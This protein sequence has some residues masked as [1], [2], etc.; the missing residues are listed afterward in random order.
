MAVWTFYLLVL[1]LPLTDPPQEVV[2]ESFAVFSTHSECVR[3]QQWWAHHHEWM[4]QHGITSTP[5][6]EGRAMNEQYPTA[7]NR[8][9]ANEP[10]QRI[11]RERPPVLGQ[12]VLSTEAP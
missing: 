8:A 7:T 12:D 10:T 11:A 6:Q 4:R 1:A 5:C 2:R 9:E 3:W